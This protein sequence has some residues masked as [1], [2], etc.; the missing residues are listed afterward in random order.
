M[1]GGVDKYLHALQ[2]QCGLPECAVVAVQARD[3]LRGRRIGEG[4]QGRDFFNQ[5]DKL[6]R[7]REST[8]SGVENRPYT[9]A[10]RTKA[11]RSMRHRAA[12]TRSAIS[13]VVTSSSPRSCRSR[14]M[15]SARPRICSMVTG[16]LP[17]GIIMLPTIFSRLNSTRVPSLFTTKTR[18]RSISSNVVYLRAQLRHCLRRRIAWPSR[19]GRDSKTLS[20]GRDSKTLSSAVPQ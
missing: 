7:G 19:A 18:I 2:R 5:P 15:S 10:N 17:H 6:V 12:M 14:S 9:L 13:R 3:E 11:T 4:L 16:R 20:S 8:S 1:I